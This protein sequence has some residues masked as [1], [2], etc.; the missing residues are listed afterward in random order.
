MLLMAL[1][2]LPLEVKKYKR[3]QKIFLLSE[4]NNFKQN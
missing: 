4:E 1:E 3:T 2:F